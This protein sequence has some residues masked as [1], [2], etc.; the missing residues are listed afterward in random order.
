LL[1]IT[2]WDGCCRESVSWDYTQRATF[3]TSDHLGSGDVVMD[4][5][6]V[7][8]AQ[9]SFTPFGARRGSNWQG[10]PS[11]ANYTTFANTTRR[12]FTGHEML[13]SVG[14]VHMNGRVYDP[15]IGRFLSADPIIQ[16]I[17]LSQAINPFSYVM[18]MPL[19]LT[20]PS[21]Y[22]WLG[23]L[24]SG[25][26][27]FLRKWGGTIISIAFTVVGMPFVGALFSSMFNLAVNGGTLGSFLTGL[28][29]SAVAGAV[30]GPIGSKIA[31]FVGAA[32]STITA[33]IV[34]GAITGGIAGGI[35]SVAM[36]GSF[37][38]GFLAG[39]L[40]GAVTAGVMHK[41]NSIR[42][43]RLFAEDK[44]MATTWGPNGEGL[45]AQLGDFLPGT[46]LG[47]E[48]AMYWA[49]RVN[50]TTAFGDP[51]ARGGLFLS[52]LWTPDTAVQTASTLAGGYLG[53]VFGPFTTRGA[54]GFLARFREYIRYDRAHHF[55]PPGF[56]GKIPNA[57]RD[58]W[59]NGP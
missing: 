7:V 39:A 35:S 36:G 32:G 1:T 24:F 47:D 5:A 18:N 34:A 27:H 17:S 46:Q 38:S 2:P 44:A 54:P 25:I 59:N 40:V 15:T 56:D 16:T 14:L 11:V 37:A 50:S 8:L 4:S 31:G 53:R 52:V 21:G 30:A 48:A 58:W 55:K 29:I 23:K 12:G 28:A 43:A 19:M 51:I 6:G 10:V 20:D 9:Q 57:I 26:G 22:S 41:V 3:L 13:D 45:Y 33:K 49:E 42:E